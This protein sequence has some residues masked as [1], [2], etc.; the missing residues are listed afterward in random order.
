MGLIFPPEPHRYRGARAHRPPHPLHRVRRHGRAGRGG[1][2]GG[3]GRARR[4]RADRPRHDRGLG[5]GDATRRVGTA[6]TSC[7]APRSRRART[8]SASTCCPTCRT[9]RTRALTVE[10]DKTRDARV[11]RARA[12]V[13]LLAQDYP[14]TWDD[15]V[16]QSQDA[17]VLGRPH[18]ADALVARGIVPDRDAAFAHLL[19]ADGPYHVPHYAP[20][21]V[22]AVRAI[23]ASGGVPVFAHPGAD[24]R[25][26]VVPDAVFDALAARRPGRP[27]GRPPRPQP[28]AARPAHRDRAAARAVRRPGRATTTGRARPT[29]SART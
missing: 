10:L 7:S 28:R 11:D 1:R 24:A 22:D 3:R 18:I 26:E 12:I 23:R 2:R 4:R 16:A 8:A 21:G 5:R 6:S 9:R 15:V 14:I 25:G 19:R 20:A 27:R 13:E 17:V 29:G